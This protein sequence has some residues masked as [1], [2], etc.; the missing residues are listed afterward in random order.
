MQ[1][2][3]RTAERSCVACRQ[4]GEQQQFIR[5]VL[6]PANQVAVD[7]RNRLPGRG[8][9]TCF[10]EQCVGKAVKNGGFSRAFRKEISQ[11]SQGDLL[12]GIKT[13]IGQ[14]IFGLLGIARKAGAVISGTSQLQAA[15]GRQEIK[16]LIIA[17]DVAD[18]SVEKIT[19]QAEQEKVQWVRFSSQELLGQIAGR[20]N[21]N[22]I[23]ITDKQ[24]AELLAL[25]AN[26]LQQIAGEN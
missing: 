12:N 8:A 17:E 26:R 18:G 23:G 15:F 25:E 14:R 5:Y 24:F 10:A 9:Y 4:K 6:G 13:A 2:K 16:Y 11:L 21:R 19:R 7:Y 22:C 3:R 1:N 20:E